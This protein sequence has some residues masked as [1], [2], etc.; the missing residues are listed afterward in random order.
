MKNST[1]QDVQVAPELAPLNLPEKPDG[2]GAAMMISAGIGI[3]VLGLTCILAEAS[4][5][6]S[7]FLEWWA[8]DLGVGA[9]AG[10]TVLASLAYFGSLAL[11]WALWKNKDVDVKKVFYIA[12]VLGILGVIAMMPPVF[13]LFAAE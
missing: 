7:T 6:T 9:L 12:L 8:F 11:F 2:P 4:A 13:K 10:K 3:F 5:S 1:A